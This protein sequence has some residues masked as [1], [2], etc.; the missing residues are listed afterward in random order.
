MTSGVVIAIGFDQV[1]IGLAHLRF[2]EHCHDC[3]GRVLLDSAI[4]E[5]CRPRTENVA[6]NKV[7]A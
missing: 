7:Y 1:Y 4:L 5:M 2:V 6:D 3:D